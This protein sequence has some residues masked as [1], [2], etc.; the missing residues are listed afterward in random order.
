MAGQDLDPGLGSPPGQ[1]PAPYGSSGPIEP[2]TI[3]ELCER[4]VFIVGSPRSGTSSFATA[5]GLHSELWSSRETFFLED[6]LLPKSGLRARFEFWAARPHSWFAEE[7]IELDEFLASAG[8]GLNALF[9]RR[10]GGLRWIDHTPHYVKIIDD[11]ARMFPTAQFIHLLRDGRAAVNS[12]IHVGNAFSAEER[13]EMEALKYI[14]AWGLDIGAAC[15]EWAD[16]VESGL[17][18]AAK[19][20]Q[21]CRTIQ[22]EGLVSDTRSTMT[23]VFAFLDVTVE[24][25]PIF[26]FENENP[27]SSFAGSTVPWTDRAT[28]AWESWSDEDREVFRYFAADAFCRAGYS[29]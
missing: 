26:Y 13:A 20:P 3:L 28:S 22:F 4:P 8:A 17:A 10:A 21:R 7:H 14:P 9:T 18:A 27:F 6:M 11:L 24:E 25:D 2:A 15:R 12:M 16:S 29:F 19:W 5:L 1:S 23:E